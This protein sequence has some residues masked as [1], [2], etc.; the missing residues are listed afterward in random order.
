MLKQPYNNLTMASSSSSSSNSFFI[1]GNNSLKLAIYIITRNYN[2]LHENY[3]LIKS[4]QNWNYLHR[5][6]TNLSVFSPNTENADQNNSEYGH[7]SRTD[8]YGV[9]CYL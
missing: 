1:L 6:Q 4:Q 7:F 5:D 8:I 9:I 3:N 2:N